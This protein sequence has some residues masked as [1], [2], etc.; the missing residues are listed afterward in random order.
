MSIDPFLAR[1]CGEIV[2]T[3]KAHT[4]LLYGS[5][6]HGSPSAHSDYDIAA[7]APNST[8]F[9]DAR[10]IDGLFLDLFVYP[11]SVLANPSEEYL[12]LRRSKIIRQR[13]TEADRF[14]ASLEEIFLRGPEPLSA[15]EIAARKA[16]SLKMVSRITRGDIEGNYRRV[17]LLTALLEDYF[18]I[19]G[20][21]YQGPKKALQW[22]EEFDQ[23][24]HRAFAM[25]LEPTATHETIA[26][27]VH[28][29][30]G[31]ADG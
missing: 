7:F 11:E 5:R 17:S 8:T 26:S 12:P 9:R 14:L 13:Q 16:W 2:S 15:D 10:N 6:A 19:R 28:L 4:I 25:A 27:L 29:L 30:V 22:L 23:P 18:H 3:H 1:I 31:S 24:A 20:A 21:W